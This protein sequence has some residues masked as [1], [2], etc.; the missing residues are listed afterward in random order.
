MMIFSGIPEK[1]RALPIQFV[2]ER[3]KEF[4]SGLPQI[5]QILDDGT[6]GWFVITVYVHG[7]GG[8]NG[9]KFALFCENHQTR[10]MCRTGDDDELL[11]VFGEFSDFIFRVAT[12]VGNHFDFFRW[13]AEKR[14]IVAGICKAEIFGKILL[15]FLGDGKG[16]GDGVV[17]AKLLQF[18][19]DTGG[20][21]HPCRHDALEAVFGRPRLVE[22]VTVAEDGD[23]VWCAVGKFLCDME[24]FAFVFEFHAGIPAEHGIEEKK[25]ARQDDGKAPKL[26]G[27]REMDFSAVDEDKPCDKQKERQGDWKEKGGEQFFHEW[28]LCLRQKRSRV[29]RVHKR[30]HISFFCSWSRPMAFNASGEKSKASLS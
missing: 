23:N 21:E 24:R 6:A 5:L 10:D 13:D 18:M 4:V 26:F 7:G 8:W 19:G 30:L 17:D 28:R 20:L 12:C 2:L 9:L 1:S 11:V 16:D 22:D 14:K 15:K 27:M 25:N 29:K 3:P